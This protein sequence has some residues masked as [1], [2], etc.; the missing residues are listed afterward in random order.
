MK[1]NLP[2]FWT[3]SRPKDTL[4]FSTADRRRPWIS[5]ELELPAREPWYHEQNA[6]G[7]RKCVAQ[8]L[9]GWRNEQAHEDLILAV[10]GLAGVA[11]VVT[12][13]TVVI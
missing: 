7:S 9:S 13:F 8:Q 11:G 5:A 1:L 4:S 10:L 6:P 3:A 12:A 2:S